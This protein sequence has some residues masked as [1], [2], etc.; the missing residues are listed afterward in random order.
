MD[1]IP[2]VQL[3]NAELAHK[4]AEFTTA[5]GKHTGPFSEAVFGYIKGHPFR[6]DFFVD[7]RTDWLSVHAFDQRRREIVAEQVMAPSWEEAIEAYPWESVV[8][9]ADQAAP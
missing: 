8:M 1:T 9:V 3:V 4:G 2:L 6:L 5:M 7:P